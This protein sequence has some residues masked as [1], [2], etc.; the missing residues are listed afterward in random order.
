MT[1]VFV[2]GN[3]ETTDVWRLL[4]AELAD[5]GVSDIVLLSPPGFGA[6]SPHGFE[7]TPA[8]Y[9]DWLVAELEAIGEPVDL[10]GHD[11]GAGHTFG[12]A[13]ARPDLLRSYAADCA[14]LMHPDYVW[15]DAAQGWQTPELGEQMMDGMLEAGAAFLTEAYVGFGLPRDIAAAMAEAF[16]G[17]MA[18]CVLELYR[19][20]APPHLAE[21]AER[22]FAAPRLPALM[23][24][25][26][27]DQYVP[28]E[29]AGPVAERLNAATLRLKDR[30][31]WW[32]AEAPAEAARGLVEFWNA[33]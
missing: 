19:A 28:A 24:V 14:G 22:L 30:G 3:P 33:V 4:V 16:N 12:L 15:H 10:V 7:A 23:I 26:T 8:A 25:A 21:A 29:L 20:A 2:H 31:H 17:D 6:P 13:T 27:N 5:L 18:H 32:M 11:W 1:K 9:I